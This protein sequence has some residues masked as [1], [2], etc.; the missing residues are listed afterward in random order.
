[1]PE[2]SVLMPVYNAEEFL[3]ESI[4]SVLLQ[5]FIDFKLIILDDASTD[6]SLKIIQQYAQLDQRIEFSCNK[7]N[8]GKSNSRNI[9]LQK[10]NTEFIAW[11]DADDI[12][13]PQRLKIQYNFLQN[14]PE[15]DIVGSWG[16]KIY[17]Q[18]KT[19]IFPTPI[20]SNNIHYNFILWNGIIQSSSLFHH[21]LITEKKI[22]YDENLSSAV[23]YQF[24][25][26]IANFAKFDNIPKPLIFYRIHQE[27]ESTKNINRQQ[28]CH[29]KIVQKNLKK[30]SIVCSNNI[31]SQFLFFTPLQPLQKQEILFFVKEVLN[32]KIKQ[33]LY[34]GYF[35][36]KVLRQYY[37]YLRFFY[38]RNYNRIFIK[39]FGINNFYS[40][41]LFPTIERKLLY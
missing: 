9:L 4:K 27:Q 34:S 12:S 35:K 33:S 8:Q 39:D 6:N 13:M 28:T 36:K 20:K 17:A 22:K 18:N 19:S 32:L 21:N 41:K 15:I 10:A 30:F 24:W 40:I 1:M 38:P 7:T 31:L 2:I 29:L 16:R 37:K 5:T 23:D 25:A 3:D 14:N 26:D 11:M